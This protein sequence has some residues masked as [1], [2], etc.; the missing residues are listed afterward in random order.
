[1]NMSPELENVVLQESYVLD[2]SRTEKGVAFLMEFLLENG[3]TPVGRLVF[4][5][6]EAEE[7]QTPKGDSESLNHLIAFAQRYYGDPDEQPDMGTINSILYDSEC[8]VLSGDW[9]SCRLRSHS[10]PKVVVDED[11][12]L[13]SGP[14]AKS[15]SG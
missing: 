5:D 14:L 7:W 6:V 1:V 13:V 8:W 4:P 11:A 2:I 3:Q 9:G 12:S 10:P 15:R